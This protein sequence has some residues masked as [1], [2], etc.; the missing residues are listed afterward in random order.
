LGRAP[1]PKPTP[2]T[3]PA[4]AQLT[5]PT[6]TPNPKT[7]FG[8]FERFIYDFL[9]GG[10]GKEAPASGGGASDA[11]IG[12]GLRLK[13]QTPLSVAD[14]LLGAA[15]RQLAAE[16]A[17]A[18]GELGALAAVSAQLRRFQED[19]KKDAAAQR[20]AVR[21]LVSTASGRAEKFVD[22]TLQI[23]N[24][25]AIGAYVLGGPGGAAGL[26]VAANFDAKV[27]QGSTEALAGLVSEHAGWLVSNCGAQGDYY[28]QYLR[29]RRR[30]SRTIGGGGSGEDGAA[31]AA[32]GASSSGS[33]S[34]SG[35][36]GGDAAAPAPPRASSSRAE[37][38]ALAGAALAAAA[39]TTPSLRAVA[40]FN[41]AAA[42][43]L[44]EEEIREAFLG[45]AG[46][47]A[48]AQGLG[49]L[50]AGWMHNTLEDILALTVAGL[51][52]YVSVLNLPLKRS[53]IKAKVSKIAGNFADTV[54][55]A[56]E[57]ELD[58]E[59]AKTAARVAAAVA[60]LEAAWQ[61]ELEALRASEAAR[62]AL[63]EALGDMERRAANL[64]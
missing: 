46:S 3:R 42:K 27:V 55:G 38:A 51:A 60:P 49:L 4:H 15:G 56:M 57:A 40:E 18:E 19:M 7:R 52:S 32:A 59:V 20:A 22:G 45:T 5:T 12:E 41:L 14:A 23:S 17:A 13:L 35:S 31:A 54:S 26:P 63:A 29:S 16:T 44:L 1:C 47:A 37:G 24:V 8:E 43:V 62:A 10:S 36:G 30:P 53:E 2:S 6:P 61:R 39:E 21:D 64:H 34:G 58:A 9:V 28:E 50:A 48:G 11:G 33:G 25:G